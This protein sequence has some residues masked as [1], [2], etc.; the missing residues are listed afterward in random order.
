MPHHFISEPRMLICHAS[1]FH[2]VCSF[3]MPHCFILVSGISHLVRHQALFLIVWFG[4][5]IIFLTSYSLIHF[6]FLSLRF[7]LMHHQDFTVWNH[8]C[9]DVCHNFSIKVFDNLQNFL[10]IAGWLVSL[11]SH[12]GESHFRTPVCNTPPRV[13]MF[14]C[15]RGCRVFVCV[16]VS[17]QDAGASHIVTGRGSHINI[18]TIV[19]H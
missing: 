6:V 17:G 3:V 5:A 10:L 16:A 19:S 8:P 11:D 1:S 2:L 13:P 15:C 4:F 18:Y 12:F 9:C 14:N 7:S